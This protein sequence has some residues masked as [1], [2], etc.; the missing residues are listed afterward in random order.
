MDFAGK[1]KTI[2]RKLARTFDAALGELVGR[3]EPAPIEIVHAVL[4][5]AEREEQE[6]GRGRRVFPFHHVRVTVLAG[7]RDRESRARL[8][9]VVAGPPSLADR[10]HAPLGAPGCGT[11]RL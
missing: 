9:A 1:A 6:I 10:L 4:D 11:P 5:R 2:E 8:D 3:D 7:R